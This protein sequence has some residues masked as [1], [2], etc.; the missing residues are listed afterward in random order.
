MLVG[1]DGAGG[2][3]R[4]Q[5]LA[6]TLGRRRAEPRPIRL[7]RAELPAPPGRFATTMLYDF[8]PMATGLRGYL[9]IFPM[10][11]GGINVG[12]MHYP[13]EHSPRSGKQLVKILA[14]WL[15]PHGVELDGSERGWP[16]LGYDP[17]L[18]LARP[19]VLLVGDAAGVDAL[20][21]EGIAVGMEQAAVAGETIVEALASGDFSLRG[22][23][24][25]VRRAPVGRELVL[26]GRLA[27]MLYDGDAYR[28]WLSLV[29]FDEQMLRLYADRV[30]GQLVLADERRALVGALLR[31]LWKWGERRRRL[32]GLDQGLAREPAL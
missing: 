30:A 10:P 6:E 8:S 14:E 27:R 28:R 32:D 31:H 22:Y 26:D 4:K 3:V 19:R 25:R 23:T 15:R 7:F 20:T 29:L 12:L 16:V 2:V 1:A 24:R 18:P 11:S 13:S 9:W 21:G 17:T 5:L